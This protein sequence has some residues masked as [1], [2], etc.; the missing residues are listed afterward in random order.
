MDKVRRLAGQ[1]GVPVPPR[2]ALRRLAPPGLGANRRRASRQREP[3]TWP[4]CKHRYCKFVTPMGFSCLHQ[5]WAQILYES[6]VPKHQ[7]MRIA[8]RTAARNIH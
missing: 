1:P 5:H 6:G 7:A 4:T 8:Y 3:R 2:L